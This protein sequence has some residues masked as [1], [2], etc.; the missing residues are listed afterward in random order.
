M[1]FSQP[2]ACAASSSD[3]SLDTFN[4]PCNTPTGRTPSSSFSWGQVID[5]QQRLSRRNNDE[6]IDDAEDERM[7]E[8]ILI[9]SSPASTGYAA[10]FAFQQPL[11]SSSPRSQSKGH[12]NRFTSPSS[13]PVSSNI[14]GDQSNSSTF[15]SSDPFYLAQ[16]Q[17][18]QSHTQSAFSQ[19]GRPAQQSPFIQQQPRRENMGAFSS[20]SISL[21]THNMFAATSVAFER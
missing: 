19:L 1:L 14:M 18:M 9:P 6:M 11:S 7:V 3:S 16:L 4:P 21:D 15:T 10:P 5:V 8:D 12:H 17:T 2:I 20:S 13:S